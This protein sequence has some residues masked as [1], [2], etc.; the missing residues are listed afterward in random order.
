MFKTD[1]S[2]IVFA[3]SLMF[4]VAGSAQA[5]TLICWGSESGCKA[6][7]GKLGGSW[8][9]RGSYSR[10]TVATAAPRPSG[11]DSRELWQFSCDATS[12]DQCAKAC[13]EAKGEWDKRSNACNSAAS[14]TKPIPAE[15]IDRD[16]GKIKPKD[17]GPGSFSTPADKPK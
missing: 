10:C 2:K 13:N 16:G 4:L 15:L 17:V 14:K 1:L 12:R 6:A 11:L 8:Q 5:Y 9:D 7:C 3:M